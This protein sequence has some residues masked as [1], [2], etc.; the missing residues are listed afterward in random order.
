MCQYSTHVDEK[1]TAALP[2]LS[3]CSMVCVFWGLWFV[4]MVCSVFLVVV[5]EEEH[6]QYKKF[7][8]PHLLS[9]ELLCCPFSYYFLGHVSPSYF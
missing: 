5:G 2:Q 8:Y 9:S 3:G 1:V 4:R 7:C 6:L